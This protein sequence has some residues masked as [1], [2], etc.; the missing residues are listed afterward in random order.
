MAVLRQVAFVPSARE[1]WDLGRLA[2]PFEIWQRPKLYGNLPT[3]CYLK[4]GNGKWFLVYSQSEDVEFKFECVSLAIKELTEPPNE[5]ATLKARLDT[6]QFMI[7]FRAE[8]LR[9]RIDDEADEEWARVTMNLAVVDDLPTRRLTGCLSWSGLL[10]GTAESEGL[11]Y[12]DDFPL[13]IGFMDSP[14]PIARF[15]RQC[16]AVSNRDVTRWITHLRG[17][18]VSTRTA[19]APT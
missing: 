6:V 14:Q 19:T 17:W 15:V 11:I 5:A 8:W 13:S 3:S 12:L 4:A 18:E 10:F 7:L 16:R 2:G 9:P 1:C